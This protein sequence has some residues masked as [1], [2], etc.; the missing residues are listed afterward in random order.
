[1][2]SL[3][4]LSK[5][6]LCVFIAGVALVITLA[7]DWA[8]MSVI[9]L[10]AKIV[11]LASAGGAALFVRKS[12]TAVASAA[13]VCAS[14][15]K[16][17]FE[18]RVLDIRE[19]GDIGTLHHA[20]NDMVDRC[21]AF[22]REG[23]AAMSA[24]RDDKYFRR[25]L[26][27][28][29]HGSLLVAAKTI[30]EATDAIQA[31]VAAFNANTSTFETAINAIVE[32]LS[33]ASAN[34]SETANVLNK[35]S[36]VTRE[37]A[38]AV[39]AASE[40]A[41]SNMQTVAAATTELTTSAG[42]VGQEVNRSA[43]IARQ[44]VT[45]VE[46]ASRTIQGLST[47]AERI[48][49]VVELI[50]AIASQTNLL[51]LNATIEAA[52]AGEMGKGFAVVAQEVKTLAAQ[53]AKATSEISGHIS[54]VQSATGGAVEAIAAIG[55]IIGEVDQITTHVAE[56][57][58]SQTAATGEIARNVEQAFTGIRE[59][60]NNIHGVTENVGE[61]EKHAGTTLTSSQDLSVQAQRLAETVQ[62]FLLMLK[63][64]KKAAA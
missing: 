41:T 31:K 11:A 10:G 17:D 43:E 29:L 33:D 9:E 35:G 20:L 49:Q 46:D 52:R 56:A 34:M 53:T 48:G 6:F 25:I 58:N 62:D 57:I 32:S 3:S 36:T 60:T 51:A 40:E 2:T 50:S 19:H 55:K 45:K 13:Q 18:A 15:A 24:V 30:N 12:Q 47:A 22:V 59:I 1:M 61:T 8:G 4:S 7:A 21:D 37:R 64:K 16:G 27:E 42:D 14:I 54:E 63:G 5:A 39:A 44:A 23:S 26:P 38:T 28:G